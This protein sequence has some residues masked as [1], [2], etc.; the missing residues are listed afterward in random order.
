MEGGRGRG[1]GIYDFRL[2]SQ[3]LLYCSLSELPEC[4][5]KLARNDKMTE[6]A[7]QVALSPVFTCKTAIVSASY[8]LCLAQTREAH[9]HLLQHTLVSKMVE[10]CEMRRK[11]CERRGSLDAAMALE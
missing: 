11:E 5:E 2:I 10:V 1:G 7:L 9:V 8:L 6:Q 4:Q 3:L